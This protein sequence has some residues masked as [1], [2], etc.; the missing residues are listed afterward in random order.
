[1]PGTAAHPA[2]DRSNK[3][4]DQKLQDCK[5]TVTAVLAMLRAGLTARQILTKKA[6]ENAVVVVYALGGSTN[7]VLHL[8]AM[9]HEAEVRGTPGWLGLVFSRQV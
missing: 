6:F 8:L 3:V 9:A 7:A 5:D 4:T 2:V 1:M